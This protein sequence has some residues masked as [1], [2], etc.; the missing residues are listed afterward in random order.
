MIF[1]IGTLGE[2]VLRFLR[3]L[4]LTRILS[5][6]QFGIIAI[7]IASLRLLEA[8]TEVGVKQSVIQNKRGADP[9]YLNVAWWFQVLR[10]LGLFIIAMLAAPWISSFYDKPELLKLFQVSYIS[11]LFRGFI[12]PRVYV[13]EKEY[14]FGRSVLLIVGSSVLGT[15][16]T[17]VVAFTIR[18]V[19][20][21]VIGFVGEVVILC[22]LSYIFVPFLPRFSINGQCL[23]EL[24]KFARGMFGLPIL[25]WISLGA[26]VLV[27][28][29]IVANEE[30]GMY[31]LA[32][33]LISL[34]V[35]LFSRMIKPVLLPGFAQKQ[36]DRDSLYRAVLQITRGVATFGIPLVV[37]VVSCA[38]GILLL[39]YGSQYVA[40]TVPCGILSLLIL[41]QLE[42]P[43]LSTLYFAVGRPGLHR[44]YVMLRA[45]IIVV[46][47]YPAVVHFRLLGAAAVTVGS[48]YVA[49]LAQV[50]WCRRVIDIKFKYYMRCYIPGLVLAL[51]VIVIVGLM[52]L[53][54]VNSP[55]WILVG[56][57]LALATAFIG[58]LFTLNYHKPSAVKKVSGDKLDYLSSAEVRSV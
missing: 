46:L 5:P 54:G 47:I 56:G 51:P 18:S 34:P 31:S 57:A 29:K 35:I 30:L 21:L 15:M 11:I 49:L 41:A 44:R 32:A 1:G 42:A 28:G 43:I 55:V 3:L 14:R 50:F 17:I 12:S 39:T 37:F 48:N 4:I 24:M 9:E 19:W 25:S 40:V 45:A 33:H 10:G 36:D 2:R 22:L 13:L 16:I 27:L 53:F 7:I 26:G 52:R 23:R 8:F 58:G 20:A 38:S 6:D